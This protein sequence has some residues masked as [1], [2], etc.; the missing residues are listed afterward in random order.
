MM[1]PNFYL[2]KATVS[3]ALGGLLFGFDTAVIAGAIG[4]LTRLY[5]L[6]DF[7][8][9][10]TV[11]SPSAGTVVGAMSAGAI[12]QKLGGR[13][14]LRITAVFYV[15]SALG[16]MLA[17]N[18]DRCWSSASSA[19]SASALVGARPGLHHRAGP[20]QVARTHGRH[21]P[22]QCRGRH[23]AR[24]CFELRHSPLHLGAWEWRVQ[25]GVAA[26][27]AISS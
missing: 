21:L 11:F 15:I 2:M 5:H 17:W 24:L 1:R 6:T 10:I 16:C 8:Q 7:T 25:L 9:G 27:P 13:E 19:A 4:A 14:T 3:G 26:I 20:S 22:G 18:W 23:P 12:G